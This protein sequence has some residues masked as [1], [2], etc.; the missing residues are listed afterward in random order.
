MSNGK[1]RYTYHQLLK[2]DE[3]AEDFDD[4]KTDQQLGKARPDI[5]KPPA[6]DAKIFDLISPDDFI[7][8]GHTNNRSLP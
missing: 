1:S 3:W 5:Q 2:G 8:W 6:P 4:F 7:A